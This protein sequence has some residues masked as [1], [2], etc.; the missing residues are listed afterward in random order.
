MDNA[1][2]DNI[3]LGVGE[4]LMEDN[5]LRNSPFCNCSSDQDME[6][7]VQ[8]NMVLELLELLVR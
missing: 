4:D 2:K 5:N 7:D 6:L 8:C 3:I 1:D